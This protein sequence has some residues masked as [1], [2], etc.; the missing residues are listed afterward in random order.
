MAPCG[1]LLDHAL[2]GQSPQLRSDLFDRQLF[3]PAAHRQEARSTGL[4]LQNPV[5]GELAALDVRKDL[6]HPLPNALVY[7]LRPGR[8]V[9]ILGGVRDRVPHLGEATLVDKVHYKLQLVDALIVR[10]LR[11]VP[12]LDKRVEPGLQE[13]REP[14]A[15]VCLGLLGKGGLD[16]TGPAAPDTPRVGEDQVP[17]FPRSVVADREERGHPLA[18]RVQSSE[19]VART[20]GRHE[21]E[22]Y[23][24][25]HGYLIEVDVK[26]V[27]EE[28]QHTLREVRGDLCFE[29]RRLPL[30]REQHHHHVRPT[31]GVGGVHYGEALVLGLP[32]ARAALVEPDGDL[33]ARVFEVQRVGVSLAAIAQDGDLALYDLVAYIPFAVNSGHLNPSISRPGHRPEP[34]H[35]FQTVLYL[36]E[37]ALQP[38]RFPRRHERLPFFVNLYACAPRRLVWW[39]ALYF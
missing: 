26:P 32:S 3:L 37:P 30:V 11:L 20:F 39:A 27:G 4:V 38:L 22:V 12:G 28:Q 31:D 8:V 18:L 5:A 1:S 7:D 6:A 23:L 15:E 9:T 21:P 2:R 34:H 13:R 33:A 16:D 35:L 10:E 17:G 14:A 19:H 36:G 24:Q 25:R 29:H